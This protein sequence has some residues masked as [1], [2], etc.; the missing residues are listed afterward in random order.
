MHP[1]GGARAKDGWVRVDISDAR[2]LRDARVPLDPPLDPELDEFRVASTCYAPPRMARIVCLI[3]GKPRAVALR[4]LKRAW[5][6]PV[7]CEGLAAALDLAG[8]DTQ[9]LKDALYAAAFETTP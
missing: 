1:V 8:T 2:L 9:H 6:D 5:K 3:A 4:M 7:L